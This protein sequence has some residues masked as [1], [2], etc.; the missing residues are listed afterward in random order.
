MYSA[1][2]KNNSD[3]NEI[4]I[5]FFSIFL[6]MD[7]IFFRSTTSKKRKK[8]KL[9]FNRDFALIIFFFKDKSLTGESYHG[10]NLLEMALE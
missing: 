7:A 3:Q 10:Q 8:K 2:K 9:K 6:K 4:A 1:L 5:N